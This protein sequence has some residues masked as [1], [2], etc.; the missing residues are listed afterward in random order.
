MTIEEM[1]KHIRD[2]AVELVSKEP[3]SKLMLEEQ[4]LS[5]KNFAEM[6]SVTLA[7]QL[8]GEVIDRNELEKMFNALYAKYPELL[9]SACKDLNATVMRDPACTSYLEPLLFFKGFQGLQTYRMAHILWTENRTFPAKMLQSI[10][11]RK[12]G[13]DFHPAAKIGHG[14]LIDH[15]TNIVIGETAVVGNNVSFLHGV[16]LGGTGNE[17]GDRHPKIGNGVMLGAHAQLLGNIH[18]GDGAKIGAGAVVVSDVPAHTTYAGVPAVQIGRP[19]DEM[20]SFN[21]QQDFTRDV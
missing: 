9:V 20:P 19:H 16:T 5:R 8:A 21:M 14:L 3:L 17:V 2:E 4:V 6:L 1:E 10:M 15:A 7:C 13:M 12:F 11:S 18:I